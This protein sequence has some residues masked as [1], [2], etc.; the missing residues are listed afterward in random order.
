MS[1]SLLRS[2]SQG[3]VISSLAALPMATMTETAKAATLRRF[4]RFDQIGNNFLRPE[5]PQKID[6][7]SATTEA[8]FVGN[9]NFENPVSQA[10]LEEFLE[11]EPGILD[12]LGSGDIDLGSAVTQ[13]FAGRAGDTLSFS[14]NFR[15]SEPVVE[16]E[17]EFPFEDGDFA[18]LSLVGPQESEVKALFD[19]NY[20]GFMV[21]SPF[22]NTGFV[23]FS[24]TLP[25]SG[26][27][28]VGFGVT[29]LGPINEPDVFDGNPADFSPSGITVQDIEL[30]PVPA[31]SSTL[32][33]LAL[34]L[35][36]AGSLAWKRRQ[37]KSLQELKSSSSSE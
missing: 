27:Y 7:A 16:G 4:I 18:F 29:G 13:T 33:F 14:L 17:P 36:G 15:T 35:L 32:G 24:R 8:V 19:L 9:G 3:L 6:F 11:I 10:D 26:V 23:S 2:F 22:S 20:A 37:Q 21:D 34:G 5:S 25:T 30:T 28:T 12:T 31:P 1:A